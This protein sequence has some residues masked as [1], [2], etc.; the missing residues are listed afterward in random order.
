MTHMCVKYD[1][2]GVPG[3][4]AVLCL[5][6]IAVTGLGFVCVVR[7]I[8]HCS[9]ISYKANVGLIRCERAEFDPMEN[10]ERV[11]IINPSVRNDIGLVLHE[12]LIFGWLKK[13]DSAIRSIE[14]SDDLNGV[15]QE[16]LRIQN[17]LIKFTDCSPPVAIVEIGIGTIRDYF[18]HKFGVYFSSRGF[19]DVLYLK[20][21]LQGLIGSDLWTSNFSDF[22]PRS[23]FPFR[24][25]PSSV[26]SGD[27]CSP[28]PLRICRVVDARSS[29]HQREEKH[30][31]L[32]NSGS[33]KPVCESSPA[34]YWMQIC[35]L[36]ALLCSFGAVLFGFCGCRY[37]DIWMACVGFSCGVLLFCL[38]VFLIHHGLD[39]VD[40]YDVRQVSSRAM[41]G[42][43]GVR[44]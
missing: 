20:F 17:S 19:P 10:A 39:L 16:V 23:L 32:G 36:L 4:V 24:Y 31:D 2:V 13:F 26:Y 8:S 9:T 35:G 1:T 44:K 12:T 11:A 22:K 6:L 18:D 21:P 3:S 43:L 29:Y 30:P 28:L 40:S 42:L 41:T 34:G 5:L 14:S 38:S 37:G 15:G 25:L 7:V 27:H 33:A